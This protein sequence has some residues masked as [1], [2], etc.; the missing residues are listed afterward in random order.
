MPSPNSL[1]LARDAKNYT[2]THALDDQQN[3]SLLH[4]LIPL[5]T[6]TSPTQHSTSSPLPSAHFQAEGG[7]K[8]G[9][10]E[11]DTPIPAHLSLTFPSPFAHFQSRGHMRRAG[12]THT[13]PPLSLNLCT[14]LTGLLS[15]VLPSVCFPLPYL[16]NL[17]LLCHTFL[18][19]FAP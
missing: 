11:L 13:C 9:E 1:S 12:R 17:M 18:L 3:T 7:R 5:K 10:E 8:E 6:P 16:Y 19:F 4:K 2:T 14:S 15:M